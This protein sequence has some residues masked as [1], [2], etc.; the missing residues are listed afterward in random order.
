MHLK[1]SSHYQIYN[2]NNNSFIKMLENIN[3]IKLEINDQLK[4]HLNQLKLN[5]DIK[6]SIDTQI[7]D[8][9]MKLFHFIMKQQVKLLRQTSLIEK[10]LD[11]NLNNLI[12]KETN[13]LN[14]LENDDDDDIITS[15][16]ELKANYDVNNNTQTCFNYE[17]KKNEIIEHSLIIG[18]L[19]V[20]IK[21]FFI[22]V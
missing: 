13:L 14:K 7:R 1:Y 21:Y 11:L 15:Y 4:Y 17:F 5:K 9:S 3:E 18:H 6:Q 12:K 16:N 22:F 20:I 19:L 10:E 8:T 2:N